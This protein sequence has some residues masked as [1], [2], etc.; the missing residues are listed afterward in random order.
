MYMLK[1]SSSKKNILKCNDPITPKAD[2]FLPFNQVLTTHFSDFYICSKLQCNLDFII[3]CDTH[4]HFKK[5]IF[6]NIFLI[7]KK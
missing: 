2:K 1:C 5:Y 6:Y 3:L 4:V 7:F